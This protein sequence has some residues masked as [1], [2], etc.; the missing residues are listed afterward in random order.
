MK[1]YLLYFCLLALLLAINMGVFAGG[2]EETGITIGLVTQNLTASYQQAM[3]KAAQNK[4]EELGIKLIIHTSNNDA[5]RHLDIIDNFITMAVDGVISGTIPDPSAI[6]PG[7]KKLNEAGIPVIDIDN[8]ALGG[9][10]EYYIGFDICDNSARAAEV[11]IEELKNKNN[12]RVPA[13][14]VI[15]VMGEL[16]EGFASECSKGFHSVIDKYKDLTVVQ[17]DGQ[18]NNDD[19]FRIVSDFITR[20][21]DQL[22]AVYVHTPDC[23]GIGTVNAIKRAGLDPKN[24]V[25]AGICIGPEG[26]ELLK[27]DEFDAIVE[28]PMAASAEMAVELLQ[29]IITKEQHLPK[30]GNVLIEEGALWSPAEVIENPYAEGAYIKLSGPIVPQQVSPDDPRL[31]ENIIVID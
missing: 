2:Q 8:P 11:M 27:N 10:I 22:V 13:G 3:V 6:V 21:K 28:Q 12:G 9:K 7:I 26:I 14:I 5:I 4:A 30:I 18:W 17:G 24:I 15:E 31:W 16:I 1:K 19:A 29:K 25:T 23:M 20:F